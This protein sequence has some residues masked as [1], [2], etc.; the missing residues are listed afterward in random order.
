MIVNNR[1][2][3]IFKTDHASNDK[4]INDMFEYNT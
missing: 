2:M 4:R 3:V 1:I